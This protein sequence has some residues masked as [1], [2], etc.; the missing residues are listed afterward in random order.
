MPKPSILARLLTK[1]SAASAAELRA[2]LEA[3]DV[4]GLEAA[5]EK[6]E[7]ARRAALLTGTRDQ[8]RALEAEIA[9]ADYE[10][11]KAFAARELLTTHLAEAE[12][13][14]RA[15]LAAAERADLQ[16]AVDAATSRIETELA[17]A[18]QTVRRIQA[19]VAEVEERVERFNRTAAEPVVG[20]EL[21][22][23]LDRVRPA[24][25]VIMQTIWLWC[26]RRSGQPIA[27]ADQARVRADR[28]NPHCGHLP[29]PS[30]QSPLVPAAA[31]SVV[32]RQFR[33]IT[34]VPEELLPSVAPLSSIRIPALKAIDAPDHRST[35]TLLEP[36]DVE[37]HQQA[38]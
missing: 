11:E 17:A 21:W 23:N 38:A 36:I 37:T 5:A 25:D 34:R 6:L 27:E 10:V 14:E 30:N 35:E 13:R 7:A 9:D 31:V 3:L 28:E 19:E 15:D 2:A 29:P 24:R 33:R 4:A 32:A 16:R 18:V 1:P 22:R 20:P 12:E 26:F 8:V